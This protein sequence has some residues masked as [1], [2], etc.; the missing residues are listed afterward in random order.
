MADFIVQRKVGRLVE[1]K[2]HALLTRADVDA[3]SRAFAPFFGKGA[4]PV[5]C[6][7]HRAVKIYPPV[8]ADALV[9]LFTGLNSVWHRA[10]LIASPSNAVLTMQLQRV[11]R[12][13]EGQSRRLFVDAS[14]AES[15]L[16][17]VLAP[18]E[19]VRLR[20]FLAA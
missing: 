14:A 18:E 8:V 16:Q 2:V 6:A 17:E 11:V 13:S 5:L 10:A 12:E 15:F 1:A 19:K 4:T 9:A 7:D 20:S 3:Y